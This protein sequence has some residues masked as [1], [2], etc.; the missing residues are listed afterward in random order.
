MARLLDTAAEVGQVE[1]GGVVG[2]VVGSSPRNRQEWGMG[3][4]IHTA[5]QGGGDRHAS[6]SSIQLAATL[7]EKN[8][9]N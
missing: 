8:R 7:L 5:A 6:S 4:S 1:A 9:K 2:Q 3:G